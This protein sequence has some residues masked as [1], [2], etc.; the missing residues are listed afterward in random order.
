MTIRSHLNSRIISFICKSWSSLLI[1]KV[2]LNCVLKATCT[3]RDVVV[4][5]RFSGSVPI[6]QSSGVMVPCT[7][8]K[9]CIKCYFVFLALIK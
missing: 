6:G 8:H 2:G 9:A 1:V 3:Q 5:M 7:P 4:A